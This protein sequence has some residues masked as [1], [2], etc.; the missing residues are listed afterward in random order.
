[1]KIQTPKKPWKKRI[2][3][4]L[5]LLLTTLIAAVFAYVYIFNG[6]I[7]G[8]SSTDPSINLDK[9][10]DD[11][12]KSGVKI[13]NESLKKDKDSSTRT[14]D[15]TV[16]PQGTNGSKKAV[17]IVITAANQNDG[18]LQVRGLIYD[19]V[20]DG[21]C[22]LT[23]SHDEQ[24]VTKTAEPQAQASVSSCKGFDIPVSE[25]TSG[26]WQLTLVYENETMKGSVSK[27]IT[28]Q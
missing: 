12:I 15:K 5:P 17:D 25:L 27:T 13:K 24:L 21:L 20:G 2:F 14:T 26:T 11:Q 9:P 19:V 10:T 6:S 4:V 7:L 22:T 16:A 23:L 28:I 1:M 8:W 3:I 18:V